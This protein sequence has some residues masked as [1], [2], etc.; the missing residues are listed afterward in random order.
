MRSRRAGC[1]L[2]RLTSHL[3]LALLVSSPTTRRGYVSRTSIVV[4]RSSVYGFEGTYLPQ[5]LCC[6]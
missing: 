5:D 6:V 3:A 4:R 2:R 1:W